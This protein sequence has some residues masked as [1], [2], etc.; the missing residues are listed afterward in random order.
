MSVRDV[1]SALAFSPVFTAHGATPT[2]GS[3]DIFDETIFH[4]N[5]VYAARSDTVLSTP[6]RSARLVDGNILYRLIKGKGLR[7]GNRR[8]R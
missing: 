5:G 7:Q 3:R 6:S 8:F 4:I 1:R 2:I